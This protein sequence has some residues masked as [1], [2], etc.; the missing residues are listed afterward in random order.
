MTMTEFTPTR[1]N[2]TKVATQASQPPPLVAVSVAP[3]T[4][5]ILYW[6]AVA[7]EANRISHT[8]GSMEQTGPTLSSRALAIVHLAMYDAFSG[9][10]QNP[11]DLPPYLPG[12]PAVDPS[13]SIDVAVAAA[14]S[15]TLSALFPTQQTRFT[16]EFARANLSG[17]GFAIGY[18]FWMIA[19]MTRMPKTPATWP[20]R[21]AARIGWIRITQARA[22]MLRTMA[23][24]RRALPSPS[25]L[26]W[27]RRPH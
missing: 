12:L 10:R 21:R 19:R 9:V 17:T 6:N 23:S 13:A 8:D 16:D 7:L 22:F 26:C 1:V 15:I 18:A 27:T 14:A 2:G 24:A 20:R 11:V 5:P 3:A 25:A 4:D